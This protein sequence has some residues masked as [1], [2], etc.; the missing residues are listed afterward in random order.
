[1]SVQQLDRE[2]PS[3]VLYPYR[4]NER[5]AEKPTEEANAEPTRAAENPP[6]AERRTLTKKNKP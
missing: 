6:T 1:M 2:M 3:S 5:I 4:I